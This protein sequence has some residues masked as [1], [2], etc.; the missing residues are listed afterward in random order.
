MI[1]M[2]ILL[3]IC[4]YLNAPLWVFVLGGLYLLIKPLISLIKYCLLV[5]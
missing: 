4:A 2:I 5:G 3:W 1:T